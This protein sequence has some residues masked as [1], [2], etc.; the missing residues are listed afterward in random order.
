MGRA[1][2]WEEER[3]GTSLISRPGCQRGSYPKDQ[4]RDDS[5]RESMWPQYPSL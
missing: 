4:G 5:G 1:W 3:R 2:P